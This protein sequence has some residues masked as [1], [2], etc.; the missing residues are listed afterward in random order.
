MPVPILSH[1]GEK[2]R[3]AEIRE[4]LWRVAPFLPLRRRGL[5]S[6]ADFARGRPVRMEWKRVRNLFLMS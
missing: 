6:L 3:G 4:F 5:P 2:R 1:D